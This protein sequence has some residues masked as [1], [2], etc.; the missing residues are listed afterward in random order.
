MQVCRASTA[1]SNCLARQ[2]I[3]A[4]RFASSRSS[5]MVL[6]KV[7]AWNHQNILE[8]SAVG[9]K[10]GKTTFSAPSSCSAVLQNLGSSFS[11]MVV[12]EVTTMPEDFVTVDDWQAH[13]TDCGH[14]RIEYLK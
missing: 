9:K 7:S 14:P 4:A 2:N 13:M 6:G 1:V 11:D 3:Q 10:R 12:S 8:E 5:P